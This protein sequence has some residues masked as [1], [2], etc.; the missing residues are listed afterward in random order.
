MEKDFVLM[1]RKDIVFKTVFKVKIADR[2]QTIQTMGGPVDVRIGD[3]LFEHP[4]GTISRIRPENMGE[5]EV[6]G[7]DENAHDN[8]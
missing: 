8:P 5:F 2:E 6:I 4:D 7:K 1:K 3:Y